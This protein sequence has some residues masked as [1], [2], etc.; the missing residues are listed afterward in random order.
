M[1]HYVL[2]LSSLDEDRSLLQKIK[3]TII[4]HKTDFLLRVMEH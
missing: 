1:K 2:R 3:I 4:I